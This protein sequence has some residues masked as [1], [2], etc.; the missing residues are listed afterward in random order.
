MIEA[1]WWEFEDRKSL[2][3]QVADDIEF[4]IERALAGRGHALLA[5]TGGSMPAAIFA[6]LGKRKIAW[7]KVVITLTDDRIV[8][9][10]DPLSNFAELKKMAGKTG[11]TL[12]PL[13]QGVRTGDDPAVAGKAADA[14]M[15]DLHFPPDL[16]WLG[17]GADGHTASIFPGPDFQHAVNG[18]A[19]RRAVGV[20]PDPMP[21]DRPAN[22]VT[23]T[24]PALAGG[25]AMIVTIAG[26]EKK[27]MLER[28]IEEG[29]SST[30]PIGRVLAATEAAIDIYWSA[31]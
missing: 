17:M 28:A 29:P 7:D 1:E 25:H 8:G 15:A 26:D 18:P 10:D 2:A 12:V 5:V 14:R 23:L 21:A 6:E 11:A 31:E 22:R 20:R 16:V 30:L 4:V 3:Q 27:A 19:A 13:V 24:L 9:D